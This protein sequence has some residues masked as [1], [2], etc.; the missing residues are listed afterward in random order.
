M[1]EEKGMVMPDPPPMWQMPEEQLKEAL[2]LQKKEKRARMVPRKR[3]REKKTWSLVSFFP[4][5][6]RW[7]QRK[8]RR[9]EIVI[10]R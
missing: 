3:G 1:E 10:E 9:F 4:P 5:W 8:N 7:R 2:D 6:K